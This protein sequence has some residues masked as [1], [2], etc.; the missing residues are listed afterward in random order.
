MEEIW[1]KY[2]N[3]FFG[4]ESFCYIMDHYKIYNIFMKKWIFFGMSEK[5]GDEVY[6]K[7]GFYGGIEISIRAK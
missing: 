7:L 1:W 6:G 5:F 4:N 3:I 2:D